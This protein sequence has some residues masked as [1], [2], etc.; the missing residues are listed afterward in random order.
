M[1]EMEFS[2]GAAFALTLSLSGET[3]VDFAQELREAKAA[4]LRWR[5][6][7]KSKCQEVLL[8]VLAPPQE[9]AEIRRLLEH[10]PEEEAIG[11]F[12]KTVRAEVALLNDHGKAL[13]QFMIGGDVTAQAIQPAKSAAAPAPAPA[14]AP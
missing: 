6:K 4:L 8:N 7:R 2:K 5:N 11:P 10:L 3:I 1:Q 13:K 9:H 14:A 12:L